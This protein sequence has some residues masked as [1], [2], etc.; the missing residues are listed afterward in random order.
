MAADQD[1]DAPAANLPQDDEE[2]N[3]QTMGEM[4]MEAMTVVGSTLRSTFVEANRCVRN[5]V[6]PAKERCI[7]LYD[8]LTHNF[9]AKGTRNFSS[10]SHVSRF[11]NDCGASE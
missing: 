7:K 3:A 4:F 11:G 9:N 10:V 2:N 8:N 6:Y 1:P 5:C